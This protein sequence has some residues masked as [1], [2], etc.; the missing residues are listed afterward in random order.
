MDKEIW[1]STGEWP[2]SLSNILVGVRV[3]FL[4]NSPL[5]LSLHKHKGVGTFFN[6]KNEDPKKEKLLK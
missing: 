6:Q 3:I 4:P 5:I 2:Y 1:K